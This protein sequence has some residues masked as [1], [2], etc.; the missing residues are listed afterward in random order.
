[1]LSNFGFFF[2]D[3]AEYLQ[4]LSSF[5]PTIANDELKCCMTQLIQQ[6][7]RVVSPS[8][9]FNSI[10]K[11]VTFHVSY[12]F[13]VFL[14]FLSRIKQQNSNQNK[15]KKKKGLPLFEILFFQKRRHKNFFFLIL[16]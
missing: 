8:I 4:I 5:P 7:I 9:L 13:R 10:A 2:K 12:F 15:F 1:L 16:N 11:Q 6:L 14:R 3:L